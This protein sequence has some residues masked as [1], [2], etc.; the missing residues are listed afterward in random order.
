MS[1]YLPGCYTKDQQEAIMAKV[2]EL[3]D[4]AEKE[5][6]DK[7]RKEYIQKA[8]ELLD[9]E[10]SDETLVLARV[11]RLIDEKFDKAYNKVPLSEMRFC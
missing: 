8:Q 1:V 3:D 9:E 2:K 10:G 4:K 5:R 11:L 6:E 7:I